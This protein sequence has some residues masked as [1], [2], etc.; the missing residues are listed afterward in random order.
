MIN[1]MKY[2][3]NCRNMPGG[4]VLECA[5]RHSRRQFV[6]V[7]AY[8]SAFALF[9]GREWRGTWQGE[10][11][12]AQ[13]QSNLGTFRLN[14]N[15]APALKN[16]NGSIL[17][18]VPGMPSSFAQIIVSRASGNQFFAVTSRCTHQACTVS[19]LNAALGVLPCSCHGSQ[20]AA[21]G[22]VLRGPATRSLERYA[23]AYDG[24]SLLS[25]EIP[26]LGYSV[27]VSAI[28]NQSRLRLSF[29]SVSGVKYEVRFRRALGEGDWV[30]VRFAA[31]ET[32]PLDQTVLNGTAGTATVFVEKTEQTGFF[33]V[34]RS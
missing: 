25:I 10:A 7:F 27:Q 17:L 21:D 14:L 20:F 28:S 3:D 23:T 8:A 26:G 4:L 24:A 2:R 29:P 32:G 13:T 34:I 1:M 18:R 33:S 15:E 16:D 12:A 11:M 30:A 9:N 31:T 5:P 6:K 22:T 19:P